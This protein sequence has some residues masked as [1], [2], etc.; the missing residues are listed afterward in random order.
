[1]CLTPKRYLR[2]PQS[3]SQV[4]ELLTGSFQRV[5][6]DRGPI[7]AAAVERVVF[8]SGKIGHELMDRRDR[9]GAPVAVIRLEQPYPVPSPELEQVLSRY[10]NTTELWWC[11]EEPENMGGWNFVRSRLPIREGAVL[12]VAARTASASPSSGSHTVHDQEQE[13]LITQAITTPSPSH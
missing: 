13:A 2:M 12:Q 9:D 4:E 11:Q 5:L 10:P 7:D 8:C 6:D 1:M 3:R